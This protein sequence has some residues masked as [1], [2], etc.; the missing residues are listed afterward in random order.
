MTQYRAT[1]SQTRTTI[2][3]G[4]MLEAF[5]KAHKIFNGNVVLE[6]FDGEHYIAESPVNR[7]PFRV[8]RREFEYSWEGATDL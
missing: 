5:D 1:D 4:N 8:D 7:G 6:L 3:A 2:A